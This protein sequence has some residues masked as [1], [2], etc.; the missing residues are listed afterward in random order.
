MAGGKPLTSCWRVSADESWTR[1]D[2][3]RR[4]EAL[5]PPG[6]PDA[7][8]A[9]LRMAHLNTHDF[10]PQQETFPSTAV[11]WSGSVGAA[12]EDASPG[13]ISWRVHK[14]ME[15][16]RASRHSKLLATFLAGD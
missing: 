12:R 16:L 8:H 10:Q 14:R 15:V 9:V 11:Y 2:W 13:R 1:E 7:K 4:V 3:T 6:D 5:L